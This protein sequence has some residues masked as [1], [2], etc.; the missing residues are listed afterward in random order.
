MQAFIKKYSMEKLAANQG[1]I[2]IS[3]AE[4]YVVRHPVLRAGKLLETCRFEGD[5]AASTTHF[6]YFFLGQL[7][8]VAS[9][10]VASN[11][12]FES[13]RQVQLRGMAVLE[14]FRGL[15]I[16]EELIFHAETAAR[17]REAEILWFNARIAAVGFYE[18]C[19]YQII[20]D[21]FSIGDIG[22]HYMMY[23]NL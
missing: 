10:F 3:A 19:G 21:A 9:L 2:E 6:G 23:K 18:K 8:G 17:S 14:A 13:K 15:H 20:G 12:V 1:I 5:D 4:T 7:A 22:L 11:I 16:G